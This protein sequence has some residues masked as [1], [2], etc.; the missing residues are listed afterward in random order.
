MKYGIACVALMSFLAPGAGAQNTNDGP[1]RALAESQVRSGAVPGMV[2]GTISGN[3]VRVQGYGV[4]AKGQPGRP[5]PDTVYE[6]GSLT[7]T[8]TALLLAD[9]VARGTLKLDDPVARLLPGYRI[10]AFGE[11]QI[12]L[13]DLATQTSGLPRLPD[14]MA[15]AQL[16][17]P[18]ADYSAANLKDFLGKH[19]LARAPGA[20]YDYSNLG[21]G[22]LGTALATHA[23]KDYGT[24][25]AERITTPLGM[26]STAIA[27]TADMRA[28]LAPGHDGSGNP[29]SNWDFGSM[30]GAGAIRSTGPDMLR[31]LKAMMNASAVATPAGLALV[32]KPR[33]PAGGDG[34]QIALAWHIRQAGGKSIVWHNGMTGGYASFMGFTS[35]GARG[36]VVLANGASSVNEVGFAA[37]APEL[38]PA[39]ARPLA[40]EV[41]D[42]YLGRYRL[43]PGVVLTISATDGGLTAQATGQSAA[44]IY[45]GKADEFAL[46]V[47]DARL[48][49]VRGASGKVESVVLHQNGRAMP[50]PR[51]PDG[52]PDAP[53][54]PNEIQLPVGELREYV[55]DYVL[56]MF[57]I[58]VTEEGGRLYIQPSGQGRS[59]VFPSARDEVFSKLVNAQI[60]FKRD[61]GGK[62]N[63]MVLHQ[64]GQH[65]PGKR[66]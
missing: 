35:D 28:R 50:A 55:G 43:A 27:L 21:F 11:R 4:K 41:L 2:I 57:T 48:Q 23:G 63:A 56:P 6:I 52:E 5:D 15:P 51:V 47:V 14:N 12:T 44:A 62:V 22:L 36:V 19:T 16:T 61:A 33:L 42:Q 40:R 7:K 34:E 54:A 60:S 10:P 17:N 1:V 65:V 8:F 18:Y 3:D 46:R 30:A 9:A 59:E 31:Y 39:P 25:L 29:A 13:L 32:Q 66:K 26:R 37:L 24:L 38:A 20:R 45:P 53:P 58:A 49:F 64:G